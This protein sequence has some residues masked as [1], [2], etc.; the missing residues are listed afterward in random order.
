MC[1]L[2]ISE[3][4]VITEREIAGSIRERVRKRVW[5]G[6]GRTGLARGAPFWV[7]GGALEVRVR[8]AVVL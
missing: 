1:A 7:R 8:G 3:R 2:G 4:V 6:E 5:E